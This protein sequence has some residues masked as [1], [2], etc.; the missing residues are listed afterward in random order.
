MV[1]FQLEDY[2]GF[3]DEARQKRNRMRRDSGR[4]YFVQQNNPIEVPKFGTH[5]QRV[6]N[7]FSHLRLRVTTGKRRF[8][9]REN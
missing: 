5:R 4:V 1:V 3:D 7:I 9:T 6:R 8:L 2:D